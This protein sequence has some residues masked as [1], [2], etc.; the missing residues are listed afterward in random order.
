MLSYGRPKIVVEDN[1]GNLLF[2]GF[3]HGMDVTGGTFA[4]GG[5]LGTTKATS[6]SPLS[7]VSLRVTFGDQDEQISAAPRVRVDVMA[8]RRSVSSIPAEDM[9]AADRK[10]LEK[11]IIDNRGNIR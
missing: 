2:C 6:C 1:N 5:S 3:E 8:H 10:R 4:T 9:P 7:L 11:T